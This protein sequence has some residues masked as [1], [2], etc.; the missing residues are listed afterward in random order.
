M[1]LNYNYD[2]VLKKR[3]N[4]NSTTKKLKSKFTVTILKFAIFFVLCVAIV[5]VFTGFGLIHGLIDSAPSVDDINI[6]PSG[7]STTIYDGD[8]NKITKLVQSGSNREN[9]SIDVIPKCLQYAFIDIE[10]ERFYEHNGIDLKGIIRAGF[11]AITTRRFSQG[12]STLTQQLLKNNVFEGGNE[13]SLGLL[14]KRKFQEQYLALELEKATTKS[15]ILESYLNTINLGQNCLGVQAAAKRYFNKDVSEITLSEAAVIAAITQSP[16]KYNPVT[17][18]ENNAERR[19]KVLKNMLSSEHITQDEYNAAMADDV[20]SRIQTINVSTSTSAPYSYFVD[21]LID[22]VLEDLQAQKGYTRTQAY[23]ALYSGGLSIFATQDPAIQAICDDECNNPENYPSRIYYS[24]NWAW[25]VQHADGTV[26]NYSEVDIEYYNTT[27]LGNQNFNLTFNTPEEANEYIAAFK[28]EYWQEGDTDLAENVLYT[29]QPQVSFTV[30]DQ[31]TGYVKAVVGGRGEKTASLTLNRATDTTRQPGSCF[32]VL[33]AYAPALDTAGYTLASLIEDSPFYDVNGRQVKN[34]W[35][36]SYRGP[37]TLRSGIRDSMNVITS[38]L[39]TDI[40]PQLGFDYVENFGISTLV[41]EKVLED[42]TVLSDINQSL[43]LGGITYGVTNLELCAAYASIANKGVY[44]EP[45]LYTKVLDNKGRILLDN[46]PST[47]TVL[48]ESTAWLLTSAMQDVVTDGTGK[49]CK[50]EGMT[51]AGK[52]G[53]T[54]DDNDIW[55]AGYTPYLTATVWSGFDNNQTLS[56]TAYHETLWSKIMTR[57]DQTKGFTEDP[58]FPKPDNVEEVHLCSSSNKVATSGCPSSS[59]RTEYYAKGTFSSEQC[60]VHYGSSSYNSQHHNDDDDNDDS[61]SNDD[62]SQSDDNGDSSENQ[63][64]SSENNND[65]NESNNNDDS[66]NSE[67][68]ES[69]E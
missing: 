8:G 57:I 51:V 47:H 2:N 42:G 62:N 18:P 40:T 28:A 67:N 13:S 6:A 66:Q 58:G 48:K 31:K 10:D 19:E 17:H 27:L 37:S 50:V 29:L 15:Y 45:V 64:S 34:W 22:E 63:D 60:N 41:A 16:Y 61:D 36:N 68:N 25:S 59:V 53:T 52:T 1:N 56:N 12:A 43:A 24:I 55:F 4:M 32:K 35:G 30:M 39:L 46:T 38:K 26:S 9:V 44:T 49:L 33:S 23:N 65:N 14:F 21:A 11:T 54:S 3:K 7:Y 5:V 20:Y 69:N